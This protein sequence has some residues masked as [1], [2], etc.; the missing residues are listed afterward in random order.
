MASQLAPEEQTIAE[1]LSQA[2]Y[3]TACIGKWHL[4]GKGAGPETQGFGT[5]FAGAANT[6]PSDKEGGKGEQ[7]LT[8]A[9]IDFITEHRA[10]PFFLYLAHN[11]PHVPLAARKE[12]MV[13]YSEAF[14]P[15][16]AAMIEELDLSVG[17]LLAKVEE[18]GIAGKT[19]VVFT[20]DNGGLHVPEGP[21]TPAT[22][23]APYRAGKG[24]LYE[25]GLRVP[26]MIRLP[27]VVPA[28][29]RIQQ[30]VI[31]TDLMPTLLNLVGLPVPQGLDGVSLVRLLTG[32][33]A[34]APA[35]GGPDPRS[36]PFFWHFP[37][38]TNQGGRPAGAMR[39]GNW[40]LIEQYDD[41]SAELYDLA[42]DIGETRNVAASNG[43]IV[44]AMRGK[45]A[46]WRLSVNARMN[47]PNPDFQPAAY[48]DS[49]VRIDPSRIT[50]RGT[51]AET[52]AEFGAWSSQYHSLVAPGAATR[53]KGPAGL[54]VLHAREATVH[55]QRLT[56]E[57]APHKN[58]LGFWTKAED[59]AD[60]KCEVKYPGKYEVELLQGCGQGSAGATVEVSVAGQTVLHTVVETGH[61]QNF[62]PVRIG[63][64]QLSAGVQTV[65][66]RP[67]TKPGVAVMDLRQITLV[68]A[69]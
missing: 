27:G 45:L 35:T 22:F 41:G 57:P 50:R 16:Y 3:A 2:G 29:R 38:Y 47:R 8:N 1:L 66:V 28:G 34:T 68:R 33:S 5:V 39:E 36:R 25:G 9:A 67:K 11:N 24:Y 7:N 18:L 17:R 51:A 31:L 46:E 69:E 40:K 10:K 65:A 12:L 44:A 60:W 42:S 53:M 61:F 26:L 14:N 64:V 15:V 55:G 54:I 37:H 4:G 6:K 21:N 32:D 20:S 23:N 62:V 13:K 19:V 43:K 58:T 49:F 56:Y 30:P 52:A 59:W 48:A 63:T